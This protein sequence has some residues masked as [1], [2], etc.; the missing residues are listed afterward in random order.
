M[1]PQQV[2]ITRPEP[3]ATALARAIGG[4]IVSPLMEIVARPVA[5]P[6]GA[7]PI[8]TSANG[9]RAV[10][11]GRGRAW[12]VGDRTAEAARAAGFDAVS[13]GGDAEALVACVLAAARGAALVHVRG[14]HARGDVAARLTAAGLTCAETV[15]YD[16]PERPLTAEA[17]AA[18]AGDV[19]LVVPL[20]SPRGARLLSRH[21]GNIRAPLDILALSAAVA[22]AA[23]PLGRAETAPRPDGAAMLSMIGARLRQAGPGL[24]RG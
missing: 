12:C 14:A 6:G 13:A 7:E 8:F 3:G 22:E 19:P 23:A 2:L 9:V 21:A 15:A 11:S 1:L 10:G 17:E 4:G 16:Q 20:Y 5:L 24:D 18:L